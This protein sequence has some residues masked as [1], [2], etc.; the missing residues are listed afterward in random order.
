MSIVLEKINKHVVKPIPIRSDG[1]LPKGWEITGEANLYFNAALIASTNSGKTTALMHLIKACANKHTKITA[2][3]ST[4]YND[5]IWKVFRTTC[6]ERGIEFEGHTDI[7]ED[8][9]N[10][11][12]KKIKDLEE[13]AMIREEEEEEEEEPAAPTL[14]D[15]LKQVNGIQ[16]YMDA[17]EKEPKPKKSKYATPDQIFIFDDIGDMVKDA[18][19]ENLLKMARHFH[20][21]TVTSVQSLKQIRPQVLEQIRCS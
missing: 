4:L 10:L 2:F 5:P 12:I 1:R 16:A 6:K 20:I 15:I 9:E 7:F 17:P 18:S 19:F 21:A 14:E 11:L 13:E 3:V 8:G